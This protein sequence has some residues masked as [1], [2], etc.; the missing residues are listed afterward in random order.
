MYVG[1]RKKPVISDMHVNSIHQM[2]ALRAGRAIQR[3]RP[4]INKLR[5]DRST[6]L[7]TFSGINY[8]QIDIFNPPRDPPN[9][10]RD[11]VELFV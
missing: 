10:L 1:G 9:R 6:L 2:R 5:C 4:T 8:K 7:K 11:L 3:T